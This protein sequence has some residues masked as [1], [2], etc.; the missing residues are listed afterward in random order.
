MQRSQIVVIAGALILLAGLYL[1]GRTVPPSKT[2][3]NSP[4]SV[5][6]MVGNDVPA[7]N[8]NTVLSKAKQAIPVEKL[9][10]IQNLENSVIRGDVKNQQIAAYRQLALVWDSL[11]QI[12]LAGHYLGEAARL[13]NSEKSLTFA[14]NLLAGQLQHTDDASVRKWEAQEA[15]DLYKKALELNPGNDTLKISLASCYI[16]GTGETMLGV[17]QLLAVTRHNP[18]NLAANL[19][20][21]RLAITSGQFEKAI[22]R[23]ENV[24]A[25]HPDNTEALYFLAEAYKAKGNKQKA[26]ELF[27]Q[28]KKLVNNPE[29]SKEIDNYI[30]S[31]K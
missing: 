17:Q 8:F 3:G 26:I 9:S 25:Q 30:N 20:L 4:P 2:N 1:F 14:A 23:L 29:F 7:A 28:C 27:E 5:A 6:A 15:I 22:T 12:H 21:G 16:D 11:R 18:D 31:F 24:R 10:L 19:M 13:E